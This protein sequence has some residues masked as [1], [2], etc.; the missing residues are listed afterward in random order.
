MPP[1]DRKSQCRDIGGEGWKR[2]PADG[3]RTRHDVVSGQLAVYSRARDPDSCVGTQALSSRKH[4]RVSERA[5][6]AGFLAGRQY[7]AADVHDDK[8]IRVD[9]L[10]A[11]GQLFA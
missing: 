3:T 7:V 9:G 10:H 6:E 5:T 2:V 4:E 1:K 8:R 11:D